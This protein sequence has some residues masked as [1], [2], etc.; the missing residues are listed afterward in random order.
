MGK[1]VEIAMRAKK[2]APMMVFA[3]A[4]VSFEKGIGDD[5]RGVN[6]NHRQ[7][8]VM[9][10]EN[11]DLVCAE[12]NRKMHWTTRRA[13]ILIEGVDLEN[14]TGKILKIGNFAL[15]ITGELEPCSRMDEQYEGLTKLLTPNWRG[16]VTCRLLSEGEVKEGD[17][18]SLVSAL[19]PGVK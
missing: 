9:T 1:V 12:Q 3:A 10:K 19:S 14:S 2:R 16:G 4:K 18:V 15:E 5:S 6:R 8:T 7:V 17:H 11:W 13:N